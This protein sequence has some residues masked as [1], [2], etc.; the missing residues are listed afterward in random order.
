MPPKKPL[1]S[2]ARAQAGLEY[3][4]T[5]GWAFLLVVTI[6]GVLIFVVSPSSASVNFNS[7]NRQIMVRGGNVVSTGGADS[8]SLSLQNATGGAITITGISLDGAASGFNFTGTPCSFFLLHLA[9]CGGISLS[10]SLC[11][12]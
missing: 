7:D 10:G 4:M 6:I 3:L 9:F 11:N 1:E 5:Y 12:I 2:H 8:V